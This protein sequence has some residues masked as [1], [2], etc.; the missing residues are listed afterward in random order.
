MGRLPRRAALRQTVP[1]AAISARVTLEA[2]PRRAIARQIRRIAKRRVGV[3][4]ELDL[5]RGHTR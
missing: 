2:V 3:L 5:R 4:K 1:N